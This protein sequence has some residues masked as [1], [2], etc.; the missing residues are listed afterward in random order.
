MS[1]FFAAFGFYKYRYFFFEILC[2]KRY[3]FGKKKIISSSKYKI[4]FFLID[5]EDLDEAVEVFK[6]IKK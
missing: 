3:R 2:K 4:K 6:K 5:P 1:Y